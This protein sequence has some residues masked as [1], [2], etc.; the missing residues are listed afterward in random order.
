MPSLFRHDGELMI[1]HR[2]SPGLTP[3]QAQAVGL[4]SQGLGEGQV[5]EARVLACNHCGGLQLMRHDRTRERG[6]CRLCDHYVCDL[7]EAIRKEPGYTHYTIGQLTEMVLSGKWLLI[8]PTTRPVAI[9]I[10]AGV[11]H[12]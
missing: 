5:Y 11:S 3:A 12:V 8:G 6:Y 4:P 7:C 9:P 2:A 1:D 10:P